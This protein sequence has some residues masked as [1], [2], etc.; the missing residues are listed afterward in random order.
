MKTREQGGN[1]PTPD[2]V[3]QTGYPCRNMKELVVIA[4][5]KGRWCLKI[6]GLLKLFELRKT[7]PSLPTPFKVL[8][9]CSRAQSKEDK[10]FFDIWGSRRNPK[11]GLSNIA[12]MMPANGTVIGEFV[13]DGIEKAVG[14][15]RQNIAIPHSDILKAAR[16]SD[17]D[18][19]KYA[20][21]S[22]VGAWRIKDAKLYRR[23]K[24]LSDYGLKRA[25][26]SWQYV[27]IRS[28]EN[29]KEE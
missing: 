28:E 7:I 11:I 14:I 12:G 27:R 21:G 25:P 18:A 8:V 3:G 17:E 22:T 10:C 13:C 15:T 29:D 2:P 20:S 5:V 1:S 19:L 4:S 9:Y 6:F 23:P 16:V 24:E 26:Q